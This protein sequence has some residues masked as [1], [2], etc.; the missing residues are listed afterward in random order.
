MD[1]VKRNRLISWLILSTI[2]LVSGALILVLRADYSTRGIS[3]AIFIPGIV[4]F[5]LFFLR[6]VK[7][8]GAFDLLTYNVSRIFETVKEKRDAVRKSASEYISH[9]R[10][11]RQKKERYYLPYV[12][13][14]FLLITAGAIL[15]YIK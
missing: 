3:D 4:I 6:L 5:V 9:K 15:A 14:A 8:A 7:D 12:V 13:L 10:E 1:I 2:T 11:E